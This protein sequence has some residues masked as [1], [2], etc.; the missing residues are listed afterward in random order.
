VITSFLGDGAMIRFGPP[1][2]TAYDASN[3]ALC[4]VDLCNR[5]GRWIESL[6]IRGRTRALSVWLWRSASSG[7]D[8]SGQM[9]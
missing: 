8:E 6:L 4:C 1:E 2:S 5:A 3:A 7:Q 9:R